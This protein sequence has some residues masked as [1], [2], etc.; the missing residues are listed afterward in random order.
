MTEDREFDVKEFERELKVDPAQLA[1]GI[2]N[3][4]WI[5]QSAS[6]LERMLKRDVIY[7]AQVRDD[8]DSIKAH[9]SELE[10]LIGELDPR[11]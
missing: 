2:K 1:D 10:K 5:K 4:Y 11:Q 9:L 6:G 7:P 3:A 8:I